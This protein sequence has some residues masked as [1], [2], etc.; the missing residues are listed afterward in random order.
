MIAFTES[1][2]DNFCNHLTNGGDVRKG[3]KWITERRQTSGSEECQ[4]ERT[5]EITT[6]TAGTKKFCVKCDSQVL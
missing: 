2:W 4:H 1:D 5:R 3:I 6:V